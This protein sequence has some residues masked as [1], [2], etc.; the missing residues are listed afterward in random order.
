[1]AQAVLHQSLVVQVEQVVMGEEVLQ[2]LLL[3]T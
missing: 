3:E 1:V 2:V